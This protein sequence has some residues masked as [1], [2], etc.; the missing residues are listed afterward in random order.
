VS[1]DK[2]INLVEIIKQ[3]KM[4][5]VKK[6]LNTSIADLDIDIDKILSA[7]VFFNLDEYNDNIYKGVN[8]KQIIVNNLIFT[9]ASLDMLGLHE[10][11]EDVQ[12]V[13]NKLNNY[14]YGDDNESKT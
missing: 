13:I 9:I 1:D 6:K 10:A 2:V 14:S 12:S 3:R 4:E 8:E 11:A 7:F 5:N